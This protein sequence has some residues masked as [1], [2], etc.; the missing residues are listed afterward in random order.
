MDFKDAARKGK[1]ELTF[2]VRLVS[3]V[4]KSQEWF[5][6][7]LKCNDISG[8]GHATREGMGMILL[9]A[10]SPEDIRPNSV[11]KK[12]TD[13]PTEWDG[14]D[15]GWD[16]LIYVEWENLD[17]IVEEVRS[18]GGNIAIEPFEH[19]HGGHTYKKAHLSDLDGYNLVLSARRPQTEEQINHDKQFIFKKT[20]QVRLVS[21]LKKSMEWYSN[22]LGCDEVNNWG[23]ARRGEMEVILQQAVSPHDV[24]PNALSAKIIGI[25][26]TWE[27]P[28]EPWDTFVHTPW[29][30]VALI[31]D[32]VR[33][34]G[35]TI[36]MEP[37]ESSGGG[38]DF[39]NAQIL[40]PDG[41]SI[42]LGGMRSS[43]NS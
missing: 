40:D 9:Q 17:Y 14:P 34:K 41:Y 43:N 37:I 3:D 22:V 20:Y 29:E 13:Y 7:V 18:N 38:W 25:P 24:R 28:D 1:F 23:Y 4:K 35:G 36:G 21:D 16:S 8:Y 32:E 42:I 10:A 15:Y 6:D 30:D 2:P 11:P 33:G 39:V 12:H 19:S 5:R 26:D 27:G 31:V